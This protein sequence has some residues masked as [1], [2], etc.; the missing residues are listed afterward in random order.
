MYTAQRFKEVYHTKNRIDLTK[1]QAVLEVIQTVQKAGDK[2]LFDYAKQ[3][4]S[5]EITSLEIPK[6]EI[7]SAYEHLDAGLKKALSEAKANIM[8]YQ[9]SIQWH[10]SPSG[11]LYQKIHPLEKVGIYVPGGKASYPSTVLMTAVLAKVAGVKEI[12]VL[13]PPQKDGINRATL[14]ACFI[15]EVDQVYQVGGAQAI[16]ALA[17][18]TETIPKVDKIV[19]PGNEYVAL[20]KKW[21]YGDV[22]I[23]S[24]AGPSEIA[25]VVDETANS[26]W[27]ALDILAQAEH[28]ESARTFLIGDNKAKLQDIEAEINI[29]KEKQS[30]YKIIEASLKNNHYAILT[31]N[32]KENIDVVNLIAAEHVSIQTNDAETYV[33]AITTAGAVFIGEYS[34]EAIGDYVAGPSHV[35]PT[36]GNARFANGLSVNDFL[37]PNSVLHLKKETFNRMASS[38]MVIAKEETLQAHHDSLAIR[39]EEHYD[40]NQ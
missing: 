29:Q 20:A 4:D 40:Q 2:A 6:E 21:V 37:R 12:I 27:V 31:E 30:R 19:G 5:V 14:A 18:G 36:G 11:E 8:A 7:R 35:L 28:D 33:D 22:G 39:L 10:Q 38:G 25:V 24:I 15:A 9:K 26:T 17:Y 32:R 1:S 3:F 34:P 23:D 13:T 16:A